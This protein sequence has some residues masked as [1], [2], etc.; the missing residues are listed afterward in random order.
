M[1]RGCV[2]VVPVQLVADDVLPTVVWLLPPQLDAGAADLHGQE[3]A[4]LAGHSLL[5]LHLDGGRQG[6]GAYAG[7]GL[8]PDGVDGVRCEVT[9]RGQLV[10]VHELGLPLGE[11]HAWCGGVVHLVARHHPVVLLWLVPLYDHRAGGQR[12]HLKVAGSRPGPCTHNIT[13]SLS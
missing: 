13:I 3:A 7:V 2:R 1:Y 12:P 11:R 10:V 6:A 8:H 9:D 4:G 5:G